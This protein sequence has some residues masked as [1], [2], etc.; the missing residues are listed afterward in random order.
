VDRL[1]S[2]LH[3]SPSTRALRGL[4]TTMGSVLELIRGADQA[5]GATQVALRMGVSRPTAQRYLSKLERL[6]V[7]ELHL[8]YGATGRP[9]DLYRPVLRWRLTAH[10]TSFA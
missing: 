8:A 4:G 7:I 3:P 5:V 9:N 6:G 10:V 1:Y 2:M